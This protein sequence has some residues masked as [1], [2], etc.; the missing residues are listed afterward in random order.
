MRM[1]ISRKEVKET[2]YWLKLVDTGN[3]KNLE[4]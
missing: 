4:K 3:D 2:C 1:K